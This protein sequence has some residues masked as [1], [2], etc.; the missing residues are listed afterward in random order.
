MNTCE[1]LWHYISHSVRCR[2]S[3]F[4]WVSGGQLRFHD[5]HAIADGLQYEAKSNTLRRVLRIVT[6]REVARRLASST[7]NLFSKSTIERASVWRPLPPKLLNSSLL[8][9][10]QVGETQIFPPTFG[11]RAQFFLVVH[12]EGQFKPS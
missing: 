4:Q 7:E 6:V 1:I 10:R 2:V 11:D 3:I 12:V 8:L 5:K 9:G